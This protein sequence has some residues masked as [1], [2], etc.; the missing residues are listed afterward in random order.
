MAEDPQQFEDPNLKA[1]LRRA[2]GAP[3][4]R[5]D[6]RARIAALLEQETRAASEGNGAAAPLRTTFAAPR[7]LHP[8]RWLAAA[9]VL[10]IAIGAGWFL[11]Q[12]HHEAQERQEY[13]QANNI[14]LNDMIKAQQA[15]AGDVK[16]VDVALTDR[17]ALHKALSQSL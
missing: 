6:L 14:L 10:L 3:P 15:A 11:Y 9:A 12:R 4:D 16:P 2:V 13:L 7:R 5:P 17:D 1:V 8:M